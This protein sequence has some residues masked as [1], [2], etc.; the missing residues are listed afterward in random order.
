[1]KKKIILFNDGKTMQFTVETD[2]LVA[3]NYTIQARR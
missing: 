2:K 3:L 1:M